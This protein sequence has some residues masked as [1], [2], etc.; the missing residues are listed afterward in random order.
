MYRENGVG[1][2]ALKCNK[3]AELVLSASEALCT[4]SSMD[5]TEIQHIL[6]SLQMSS[7]WATKED[8]TQQST[9]W[10]KLSG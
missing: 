5:K 6:N 2:L 4:P 8:E 10:M 1:K 9:W 7:E 3:S